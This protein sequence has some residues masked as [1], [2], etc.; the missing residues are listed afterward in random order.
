[1]MSINSCAHAWTLFTFWTA[2][3]V[4]YDILTEYLTLFWFAILV[5]E[6]K[7]WKFQFKK[8]WKMQIKFGQC[9]Y[10]GRPSVMSRTDAQNG[11]DI[12]FNRLYS[13]LPKWP[14]FHVKYLYSVTLMFCPLNKGLKITL[15]W[16]LREQWE[17]N[18]SRKTWEYNL[19]LPLADMLK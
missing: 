10:V 3:F 17:T 9:L 12:T 2:I 18:S 6:H 1:M 7:P 4:K 11:V 5:N 19:Y 15:L 14:R 16:S 8:V 13:L